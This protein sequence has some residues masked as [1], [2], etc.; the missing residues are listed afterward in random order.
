MAPLSGVRSG[1]GPA[2]DQVSQAWAR[3]RRAFGVYRQALAG[4]VRRIV[5]RHS[6]PESLA[7][8]RFAEYPRFYGGVCPTDGT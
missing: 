1:L 6:R 2:G 5:Y 4:C 3:D 8:Q 7:A